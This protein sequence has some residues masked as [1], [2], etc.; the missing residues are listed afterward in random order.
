MFTAGGGTCSAGLPGNR[1]AIYVLLG[2]ATAVVMAIRL[3]ARAV[4]SPRRAPR[5][6][7]PAPPT[8][9]L[10][11]PQRARAQLIAG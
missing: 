4:F 7:N 1:H 8:P 6:G 10:P 5:V 3:L 9:G 11:G 2:V